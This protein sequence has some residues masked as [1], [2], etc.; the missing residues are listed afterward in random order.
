VRLEA[1]MIPETVPPIFDFFNNIKD[2]RIDRKKCYPLIEV[3]AITLLAVIALR[4]GLG[5]H[6]TIR[7]NQKSLAETVSPPGTGYP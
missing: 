4:Q 7:K 6:R 3:I 5:R 1:I 2:P